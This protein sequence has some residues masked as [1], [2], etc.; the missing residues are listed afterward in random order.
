MHR[1]TVPEAQY[2]QD[3]PAAIR[4]I[5]EHVG[6]A[7]SNRTQVRIHLGDLPAVPAKEE[8][9]PDPRDLEIAALKALLASQQTATPSQASAVTLPTAEAPLADAAEVGGQNPAA[10]AEAAAA[11][12]GQDAMAGEPP[13]SMP[14]SA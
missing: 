2:K 7:A 11:E 12:Q 10:P 14:G 8:P 13:A 3:L 5:L 1:D 4:I 9:P 6:M